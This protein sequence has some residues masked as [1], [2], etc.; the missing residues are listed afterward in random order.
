MCAA[1]GRVM[2]V[3]GSRMT[4]AKRSAARARSRARALKRAPAAADHGQ[5]MP[6]HAEIA[7]A[8]R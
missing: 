6:A 5:T 3:W 4:D 1:R 2:V 7:E 8:A